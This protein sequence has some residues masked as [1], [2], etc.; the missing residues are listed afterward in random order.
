[1]KWIDKKLANYYCLKQLVDWLPTDIEKAFTDELAEIYHPHSIGK[2][3]SYMLLTFFLYFFIQGLVVIFLFDEGAS[4]LA[5]FSIFS[6]IIHYIFVRQ[7]KVYCNGIEETMRY[8][9]YFTLC[10]EVSRNFADINYSLGFIIIISS[11][12]VYLWEENVPLIISAFALMYWL[13][14]QMFNIQ[15]QSH[16]YL[17][18]II[19]WRHYTLVLIPI[20]SMYIAYYF[21]KNSKNLSQIYLSFSA[22]FIFWILHVI[23]LFISLVAAELYVQQFS[24][25]QWHIFIFWLLVFSNVSLGLHFFYRFQIKLF[26][27]LSAIIAV[28]SIIIFRV[29]HSVL[30]IEYALIIGGLSIWGFIFITYQLF[31][32]K[33][34]KFDLFPQNESEYIKWIRQFIVIESNTYQIPSN[35]ETFGGGKFG[36]GGAG[37]S[38]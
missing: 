22:L 30:P 1:M 17:F 10:F 34:K 2:R 12:L 7:S 33:N 37:G 16:S 38:H 3:L 24:S 13:M 32:K 5:I 4:N 28:V 8:I 36:G 27:Y 14:M 35:K 20:L 6:L 18:Q 23:A 19:N 9:A 29:F 11:L 26:L 15:I 21:F 31:I 25:N